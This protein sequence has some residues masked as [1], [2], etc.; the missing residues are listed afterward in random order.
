MYSLTRAAWPAGRFAKEYPNEKDY[1]HSLREEAEA[2][3]MVAEAIAKDVKEGKIK[4]VE[5]Q[6]ANLVKLNDAGLLEAY[7][8]FARADE[9]VSKD[10]EAYRKANRDKLRRY[11]SEYVAPEK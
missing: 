2:L 4:T 6:L 9:G 5:P 10:Y 1:R 8:L 7:V 3:R 11:L